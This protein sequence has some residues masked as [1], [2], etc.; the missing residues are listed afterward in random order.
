MRI[1]FLR[2]WLLWNNW[3]YTKDKE[4][5]FGKIKWWMVCQHSNHRDCSDYY[6]SFVC[7]QSSILARPCQLATI[8][9]PG[10]TLLLQSRLKRKYKS[11]LGDSQ[12]GLG[13]ERERERERVSPPEDRRLVWCGDLSSWLR[14]QVTCPSSENKSVSWPTDQGVDSG[15]GN[16]I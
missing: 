8:D 10:V 11:K 4:S 15:D 12:W 5:R 6:K 3:S 14:L 1:L 13:R 7:V 16:R 2:M 9:K